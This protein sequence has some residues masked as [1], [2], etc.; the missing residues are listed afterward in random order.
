MIHLGQATSLEMASI[1]RLLF[2]RWLSR[3]RLWMRN[4]W[5]CMEKLVCLY[6]SRCLVN[7]KDWHVNV[8]MHKWEWS[9]IS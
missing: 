4:H 6:S 2:V 3:A 1:D 9:E 5:S 7:L 8:V